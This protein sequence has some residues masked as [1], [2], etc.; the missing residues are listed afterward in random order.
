[1]S[2]PERRAGMSNDMI[3]QGSIATNAANPGAIYALLVEQARDDG[4]WKPCRWLMLIPSGTWA[5]RRTRPFGI[6]RLSGARFRIIVT[7]M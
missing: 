6:G 7:W 3:R 2:R 5:V 4:H 1:M